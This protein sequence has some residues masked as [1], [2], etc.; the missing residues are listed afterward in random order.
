M[1]EKGTYELMKK[2]VDSYESGVRV[3]TTGPYI[4]SYVITIF[5]HKQSLIDYLGKDMLGDLIS[6]DR[7]I[8]L[9]K[10]GI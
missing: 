6:D 4:C 3:D 8:K 9:E 7:Q 5:K 2:L 10:I 1:I